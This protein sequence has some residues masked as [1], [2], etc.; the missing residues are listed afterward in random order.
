MLQTEN[1]AI[2]DELRRQTTILV[3]IQKL[4]MMIANP[5][6]I[7]TDVDIDK[8]EA[9]KPG[10]IVHSEPVSDKF[11]TKVEI[12]EKGWTVHAVVTLGPIHLGKGMV[13]IE[14]ENP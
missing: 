11:L 6:L 7:L 9:L 4:L 13:D 5:P 3:E 10:D 12:P 1:Q 14:D 2:L 8:M